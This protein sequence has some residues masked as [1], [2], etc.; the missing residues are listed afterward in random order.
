[1]PLFRLKNNKAVK[2]EK[3]NVVERDVQRL[4]EQNLFEILGINFIATEFPTSEGRIDSIGIDK[5]K[6]P[7]IIEYKR[8]QNDSVINQAAWYL[9]WLL[10]HKEKFEKALKTFLDSIDYP[11][12][13]PEIKE[14]VEFVDWS[15]PRVVCIAESYN[16][17]DLGLVKFL[18]FTIELLKYRLY[19]DILSIE[20]E[21]LQK[22]VRIVT[23]KKL[24]DDNDEKP[25]REYGKEYTV[26]DL[27]KESWKESLDL[28]EQIQERIFALDGNIEEKF[29]KFYIS[30]KTE[31]IFCEIIPQAKGLWVHLTIPIEKIKKNIVEIQ[32]VGDKG[33]WANGDI[34]FRVEKIEDLGSALDYIQQSYHYSV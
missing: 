12:D 1:M 34:K 2:I 31:N 14:K 13:N 3:R 20:S 15:N 21:N 5:N 11:R 27:F 22:G 30:Y 23:S 10:D 28:Y 16:K 8:S 24:V 33:H 26:K 18:P 17:F 19:N 9:E 32:Y 4:V 7:V 6:C 25:I 29:T